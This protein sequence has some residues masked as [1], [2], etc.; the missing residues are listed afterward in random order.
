MRIFKM[1]KK[2]FKEIF[3]EAQ[4][5]D[6]FW[7]YS[8]I[9]DFTENIYRLMIQKKM[10]KTDLAKKLGVSP[11]YMTKIFRGNA[12]FTIETMVRLARAV[13]GRVEIKVAHEEMS[14]KWKDWPKSIPFFQ[15]PGIVFQ[16]AGKQSMG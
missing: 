5:H 10:T 3:E 15:R 4:K 16:G 7:A 1:K 13:D 14:T 6:E 2:T 11:A 8:V 9:L 12:N